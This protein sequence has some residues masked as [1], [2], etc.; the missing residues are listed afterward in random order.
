[1]KIGV[2]DS[3]FPIFLMMRAVNTT[4]SSRVSNDNLEEL[5]PLL[6][7]HTFAEF[8]AR[9]A[10]AFVVAPL[11]SL[12]WLLLHVA[13]SLFRFPVAYR[14]PATADSSFVVATVASAS[15]S[16]RYCCT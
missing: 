9:S 4:R 1:M 7:I 6:M 3:G 10:S 14:L 16:F 5:D 8:A 13:S 15:L 11:S 12:L 2:T